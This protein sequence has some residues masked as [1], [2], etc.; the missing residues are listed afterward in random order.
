VGHGGRNPPPWDVAPDVYFSKFLLGPFIF[1]KST[2]NKYIKKIPTSTRDDGP[3]MLD[4]GPNGGN[5][6][7]VVNLG[8]KFRVEVVQA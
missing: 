8:R 1:R 2:R 5:V 6:R 3:R 7:V 4:C